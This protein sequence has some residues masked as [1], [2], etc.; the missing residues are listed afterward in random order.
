MPKINERPIYLLCDGQDGHGVNP[1][2]VLCDEATAF[3]RA[4][5]TVQR[6]RREYGDQWDPEALGIEVEMGPF[7]TSIE[8]VLVSVRVAYRDH[9]AMEARLMTEEWG[10]A[11]DALQALARANGDPDVLEEYLREVAL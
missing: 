10:V 8:P 5:D 6:L 11:S 7:P 4:R 2:T 9:P 1:R 3:T